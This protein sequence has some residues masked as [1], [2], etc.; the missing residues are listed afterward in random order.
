MIKIRN[1]GCNR[2]PHQLMNKLL[3][4]RRLFLFTTL[5]IRPTNIHLGTL[6]SDKVGNSDSFCTQVDKTPI[7]F[8]NGERGTN[9][10]RLD[11]HSFAVYYFAR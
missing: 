4:N 11:M 2:T 10:S 6:A 1:V 3:W 5:L 8:V 7:G 9:S